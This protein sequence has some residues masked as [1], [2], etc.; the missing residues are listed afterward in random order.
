MRIFGI[1]VTCIGLLC[2][3]WLARATD[4]QAEYDRLNKKIGDELDRPK[5]VSKHDVG[6][7]VHWLQVKAA[8]RERANALALEAGERNPYFQRLFGDL[9]QDAQMSGDYTVDL[10]ARMLL[11]F[12]EAGDNYGTVCVRVQRYGMPLWE[13]AV[14]NKFDREIIRD[15]VRKQM[16]YSINDL[17]NKW[18]WVGVESRTVAE[19]QGHY[20]EGDFESYA[21]PRSAFVKG[22]KHALDVNPYVDE[23]LAEV[24]KCV[25]R[26]CEFF[27]LIGIR[28]Q[29]ATPMMEEYL[30]DTLC[31]KKDTG[32]RH[33]LDL[34]KQYGLAHAQE[35]IEGFYAKLKGTVWLEDADGRKPANGAKV[36]VVDP[37]DGTKWEATADAKGKYEIK[38]GLLHNHKGKDEEDRCPEFRISADHQGDRTD[39]TYVGPLREPNPSEE[40]TKDLVINRIGWALEVEYHEQIR[41]DKKDVQAAGDMTVTTEEHLAGTL[42]YRFTATTKPV[43]RQPAGDVQPF[44]VM[45]D[46]VEKMIAQPRPT[47]TP[48]ANEEQKARL[49][50]GKTRMEKRADEVVGPK[51]IRYYT[52]W[53]VQ[54]ELKDSFTGS[55]KTVYTSRMGSHEFSEMK[56]WHAEKRG[57]LP[58][59][60][61][62]RT[63][64]NHNRYNFLFTDRD[65]M[66]PGNPAAKHTFTIPWTYSAKKV[67][68]GRV[69]YN[70]AGT[71]EVRSLGNFPHAVFAHIPEDLL[72][73][74]GTQRV[75]H[76]EHSWTDGRSELDLSTAKGS[77]CAA[78]VG[79]GWL[80]PEKSVKKTLSWTLRKLGD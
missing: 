71:A 26:P 39:D 55:K 20:I 41:H 49:E 22:G 44:R 38:K 54:V 74:D 68:N 72:A 48:G 19:V 43:A 50:K 31:L 65:P 58:V 69:E 63:Y 6:P 53:G 78:G 12:D 5:P 40:F 33:Y 35:Y 73:Y 56:T 15:R 10:G 4:F 77:G 9:A 21:L 18:L 29:E 66:D 67:D 34:A 24:E 70:C 2:A 27:G 30:K 51:G 79:P 62:L 16:R 47:G 64:A 45:L 76:G 3:P 75:L 25:R 59:N 23:W 1:A 46:A 52:A 14:A 57:G 13:A 11:R 42:D 17:E 32:H 8:D 28:D 60:V 61:R 36:T 80:L 7:Y 37:K